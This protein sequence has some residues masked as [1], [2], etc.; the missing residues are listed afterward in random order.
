MEEQHLWHQLP[1]HPIG[2]QLPLIG[3]GLNASIFSLAFIWLILTIV[4]PAWMRDKPAIQAKP[5]Y[6]IWSGFLFGFNGAG[7]LVT[8]ILT[9]MGFHTV[10]CSAFKPRQGDILSEILAHGGVAYFVVRFIDL[11]SVLFSVLNKKN[12]DFKN[13]M[14]IQSSLLILLIQSGV[15]SHPG[16]LPCFIAIMD[17]ITGCFTHSYFILSAARYFNDQILWKS[18][19]Y[20]VQSICYS[21]VML[22]AIYFLLFAPQCHVPSFVLILQTLYGLFSLLLT[23]FY[24][25]KIFFT[26]NNSCKKLNGDYGQIKS[27]KRSS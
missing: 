24:L 25:K 4:L 15:Y 23:L 26:K 7:F 21:I 2:S 5:Y 14:F 13:A 22:H 16:G 8:F 6:L 20:I 19:L 3:R 9:D 18:R 1:P 27:K 17:T 11:G 12:T 10:A